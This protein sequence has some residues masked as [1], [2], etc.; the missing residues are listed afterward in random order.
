MGPGSRTDIGPA[1]KIWEGPRPSAWGAGLANFV[2]QYPSSLPH[3]V[4]PDAKRVPCPQTGHL[5]LRLAQLAVG[6]TVAPR[7]RCD[8]FVPRR[9][10]HPS[11]ATPP[12]PMPG[13][14]QVRQQKSLQTS[15]I[16]TITALPAAAS[17]LDCRH[18]HPDCRA[19]VARIVSPA[20]CRRRAPCVTA[21]L[22]A[23]SR[24]ARAQSDAAGPLDASAG[25][26][27]KEG[28]PSRV[29]DRSL[30]K[31]NRSLDGSRSNFRILK[32]HRAETRL[33][34]RGLRYEVPAIP[35]QRPGFWRLTSGNIVTSVSTR[36]LRRETQVAG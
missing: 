29:S 18:S 32:N 7:Y 21:P 14:I 30:R 27:A 31:R 17:R 5:F 9:H 36:T 13:A 1:R 34:I 28:R 3:G 11:H 26:K 15:M 35:R 12:G 23:A 8:Q 16:D 6:L 10:A 2:S 20:L 4:N 33:G 22:P 25:T 24:M 19:T